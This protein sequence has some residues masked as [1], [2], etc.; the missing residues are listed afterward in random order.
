MTPDHHPLPIHARPLLYAQPLQAPNHADWPQQF[1]SLVN[2]LRQC[3]HPA[4]DERQLLTERRLRDRIR[5]AVAELEQLQSSLRQ[6]RA[7]R[8][9]LQTQLKAGAQREAQCR[10]R[11][12][13]DALT[14][15]PNRTAFCA[16]ITEALKLAQGP[17]AAEEGHALSVMMLDLDRFKP[18]NDEHG[19]A[20][21]DQLLRIVGARLQHT[22]RSGDVVGRLGGDEFA[23]LVLDGNS[24]DHLDALATKLRIAVAAPLQVGQ[25][26]VRVTASI[27]IARHPHDGA[28]ADSLLGSAD[29][30]MYRA[31]RSGCGQTFA[32]GAEGR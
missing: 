29:A 28:T 32:L 22:V 30:A 21:G 2:K 25:Q 7:W 1:D 5:E 8:E 18:V 27:G 19:H 12:D 10:Y 20:A 3:T 11:A 16:Q 17:N 26:Q 31:K 4:K 14:D 23:V 13:H 6:E 24:T 9:H 15:L